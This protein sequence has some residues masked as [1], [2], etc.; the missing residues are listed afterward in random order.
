VTLVEGKTEYWLVAE[1]AR[2]CGYNLASEAVTC[3]EIAQCGLSALLK[4]AGPFGIECHLPADGDIADQRHV[5][6]ARDY[7]GTGDGH[8]RF[9]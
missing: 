7:A 9:T 4:V 3:V 6:S 8:N 2:V 1:L 5:Q